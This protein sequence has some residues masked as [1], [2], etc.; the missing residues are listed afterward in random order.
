MMVEEHWWNGDPSPRGRRDVYIRTDGEAWE[1]QAQIGGASGRSRV[2]QCPSRA[3]AL[4]LADAWRG[5]NPS[6]R[7]LHR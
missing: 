7:G 6:W 5:S 1:V 2:Q 4:I 3:A